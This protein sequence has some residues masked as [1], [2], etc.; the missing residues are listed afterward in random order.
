[1]SLR[2]FIPTPVL[3]LRRQVIDRFRHD[4]A[5]VA[6][7]AD[8][9]VALFNP[10]DM[11]ATERNAANL[12]QSRQHEE[13]FGS[14][15]RGRLLLRM[16][17]DTFPTPLL[18]DEYF[19]NLEHLLRLMPRRSE[20]GKI[21]IGLGTGRSGSTSLT[22]LLGTVSDSCCTHENP[23]L[24]GWAPHAAEIAFHIRRFQLL[25]DH[26][27]VVADV[28]HWWLNAL[29]TLLAHFPDAKAVGL[30][31]N[32]DKCVVSFMRIKGYGRGSFNHWAPRGNGIWKPNVWDRTYPTYPLDGDA[33]ADPDRVKQEMITRYV[34]A[35]N[36]RL[37]EYAERRPDQVMLVATEDFGTPDIQQSVLERIGAS[38]MPLKQKLNVRSTEDGMSEDYTF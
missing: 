22:A 7:D 25:A 27:A 26:Y 32:L 3:R 34:I 18:T 20:P 4:T 14:V 15:G 1:M 6:P 10:S 33:A 36:D 23:P 2:K 11:A 35:Y 9:A 19:R 17:E 8:P 31:R 5:I 29:E 37:R 24:I 28:S 30:F 16:I 38:G 13:P 21:V 12:F